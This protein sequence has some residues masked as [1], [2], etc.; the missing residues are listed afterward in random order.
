LE[1]K[2]S[3]KEGLG[4]MGRKIRGKHIFFPLSGEKN[5]EMWKYPT[6]D[7]EMEKVG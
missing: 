3:R 1:L 5:T 7:K 6:K 4:D 2:Y